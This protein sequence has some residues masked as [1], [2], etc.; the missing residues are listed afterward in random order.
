MGPRAR[1]SPTD[2]TG[3]T[4]QTDRIDR[5]GPTTARMKKRWLNSNAL[6]FV[7]LLMLLLLLLMCGSTLTPAGPSA[8]A[9]CAGLV[10]RGEAAASARALPEAGS[11]CLFAMFHIYC[12]G[13]CCGGDIFLCRRSSVARNFHGV[14]ARCRYGSPN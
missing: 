1:T 9:R 13:W 11:F 7:L 5:T 2:H 4:D 14:D 10:D 6:V 12:I 3:P 8:D